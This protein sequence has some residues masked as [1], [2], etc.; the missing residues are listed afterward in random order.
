MTRK[1]ADP[2]TDEMLV[3]AVGA[4]I[5]A[6]DE[7]VKAKEIARSLGGVDLDAVEQAIQSLQEEYDKNG[8]GL[9]LE[10]IAGGVR[11]ATRPEVGSWVRS[12]FQQQ[13]RTRLTPAALETLAITAYRQPVTAPEIQAIRGKDPSAAIKSLLDW[14]PVRYPE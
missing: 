2:V 3:P 12:F 7:P 8:A 1:T 5:F 10:R 4:V 14:L 6:S 13:N 11:L 9:R